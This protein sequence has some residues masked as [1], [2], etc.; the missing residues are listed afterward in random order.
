M[1]LPGEMP[2]IA[3]LRTEAAVA[4]FVAPHRRRPWAVD[5]T[6]AMTGV[7][8]RDVDNMIKIAVDCIADA[9]NVDDRYLL[10]LVARKRRHTG[11]STLI[12]VRLLD[13][14]VPRPVAEHAA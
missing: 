10:D 11:A 13:V 3:V 4:G 9:L 14:G 7:Y 1:L 2:A 6:F 12:Q 5:L 8:V